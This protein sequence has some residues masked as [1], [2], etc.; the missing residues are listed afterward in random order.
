MD[1]LEAVKP[2]INE[3][4]K[5][6]CD[7]FTEVLQYYTQRLNE[8]SKVCELQ[9]KVASLSNYRIADALMYTVKQIAYASPRPS[10]EVICEYLE[11]A[12]ADLMSGMDAAEMLWKYDE[13]YEAHYM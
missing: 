6:W 7:P 13:I 3:L 4:T 5:D 10:H 1:T 11:R 8:T 2:A 12:I 9:N